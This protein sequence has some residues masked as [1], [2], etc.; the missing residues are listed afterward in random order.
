LNFFVFNN[1]L[2]DSIE[3]QD[4]VDN[5]FQTVAGNFEGVVQYNKDNRA[6]EVILFIFF[7]SFYLFIKI[8]V[9]VQLI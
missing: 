3:T 5:F 9:L 6:F 2:C 4:D 1:S 8:R 7:K